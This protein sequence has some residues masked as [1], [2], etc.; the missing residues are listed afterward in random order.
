MKTINSGLKKSLHSLRTPL[1][2]A[3]TGILLLSGCSSPMKSPDGAI[4]ARNRLAQLQSD[5][6]LASRAS[7]AIRTA[8][9]AVTQAE[10]PR[11]DKA[12]S[13]HLV[14]IA[15]REVDVA[16]A[17][18]ETRLLEDQRAGLKDERDTERLNSRTREADLARNDADKARRDS[19]VL[20]NQ[21]AELNAKATERGLVVTLGDMLFETGKSQLKGNAAENLSKLSQFLKTYPDRTL[22]IEG[23][24]DNLGSEE[25]N[26]SLSQRRADSVRMYLL[27]QGINSARLSAVGKGENYPV[28]GNDSTSGRALNRRVEV[29]IAN[30]TPIQ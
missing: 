5:A 3:I 16:W 6:P 12:L 25:S 20:R 8:D 2:I 24:T 15:A 7:V 14:F 30:P 10:V 11:K 22:L 28:A 26:Q 27:E 4:E 19:E 17:Q 23:H 29:I 21:I 18:A 9:A 1:V 13:E